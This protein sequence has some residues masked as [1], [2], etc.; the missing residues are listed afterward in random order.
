[1]CGIAGVVVPVASVEA[2][3]PRQIVD[4]MT[5]RL[6]HRG[7]DGRAAWHRTGTHHHVSFGHTRLAILDPTDAASQPMVD[8]VSGC[9]L[10][11]NG[12]VYNFAALR[13]DLE[14]EGDTFRSTGDTEV[15]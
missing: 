8:P 4:R 12:E 14:K 7:P 1:M 6:V 5:A 15:V 10:I 3:C 9:A 11:Y 2:R 13:A